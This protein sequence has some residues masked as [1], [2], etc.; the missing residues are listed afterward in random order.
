MDPSSSLEIF[1]QV[2]I[3]HFGRS[4]NHLRDRGERG[5]EDTN[6]FLKQANIPHFGSGIT[7][8]QAATPVVLDMQAFKVGITAFSNQYKVIAGENENETGVLPVTEEHAALGQELLDQQDVTTRIAYVHWGKNYGQ[9]SDTMRQHAKILAE[10]GYDL[11]VGSDG[12]HTVQP[13]EYVSHVPVLYNVGNF[14]FQTPGRYRGMDE[15][16]PFGSVLN[17]NL[18]SL[19]GKPSSLDLY[20][21]YTIGSRIFLFGSASLS[22]FACKSFTLSGIFISFKT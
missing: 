7:K 9:V 14:V 15:Y 21:R 20:C 6:Y 5:V 17:V 18:D 13:F 8:S 16:M 12:S 19:T 1:Q 10:H 2:G 3:T 4:N 11:I 22:S